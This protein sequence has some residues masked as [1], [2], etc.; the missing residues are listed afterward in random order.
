MLTN[1]RNQIREFAQYAEDCRREAETP[2][3]AVRDHYVKLEKH[4]L[5][6]AQALSSHVGG[7]GKVLWVGKSANGA[8][9]AIVC[10][11]ESWSLGVNPL[12][13]SFPPGFWDDYRKRIE[14]DIASLRRDLDPL[15]SGR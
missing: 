9:P 3:S 2:R 10:L 6:L 12:P 5:I 14:S 7:S 13:P 8:R 4:W 1:L 11:L 15:Q